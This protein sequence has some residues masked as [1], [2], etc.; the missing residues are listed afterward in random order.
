VAAQKIPAGFTVH[1][2]IAAALT[3]LSDD[4]ERH[5]KPWESVWPSKSDF[6]ESTPICWAESIQEQLPPATR[7]LLKTQ[8]H[9][10]EKDWKGLRDHMPGRAFELYKYYW[11]VVNTRCFFW[12]YFKLARA[13]RKMGKQLVR[14]DCIALCPFVDYFKCVGLCPRP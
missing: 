7:A 2:T 10:L 8:Q 6:E 3:V 12:E 14:D 11:L 9:K 13:R 4:P 1:G 5:Y